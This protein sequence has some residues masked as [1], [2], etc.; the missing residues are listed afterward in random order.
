MAHRRL[1][2]YS[3]TNQ[4][5]LAD[6][7]DRTAFALVVEKELPVLSGMYVVTAVYAE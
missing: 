2:I 4:E 3:F 6:C 5:Q 7:I 1:A